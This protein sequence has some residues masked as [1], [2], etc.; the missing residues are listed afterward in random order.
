MATKIDISFKNTKK[1]QKLFSYYNKLEDR[2]N[3]IKKILEDWYDKNV[4]EE[5]VKQTINVDTIKL[6]TDITDF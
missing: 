4:K 3:E 2:S 5:N 1:E 6:D